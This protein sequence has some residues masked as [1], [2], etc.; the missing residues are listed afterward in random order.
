[1]HQWGLL[2]PREAVFNDRTFVRDSPYEFHELPDA[3]T[4]VKHDALQATDPAVQEE[5]FLRV[6]EIIA[7]EAPLL[8]L[9]V[10]NDTTG[11]AP[12]SRASSHL[13]IGCSGSATGRWWSELILSRRAAHLTRPAYLE[14]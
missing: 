14:T 10:P 12:G 5:L 11:S 2:Y 4:T 3:F 8:L 6:S 13:V 7:E 9:H 1:M